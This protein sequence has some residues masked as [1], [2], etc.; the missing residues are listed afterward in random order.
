MKKRKKVIILFAIVV[1]AGIAAL[2]F[3]VSGIYDPD[4]NVP[5]NN[6]NVT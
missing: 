2:V 5:G 6:Q 1:V 3:R 4:N